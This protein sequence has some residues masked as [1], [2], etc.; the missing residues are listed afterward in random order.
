MKKAS[1]FTDNGSPPPPPL[2]VR[3]RKGYKNEEGKMKKLN[4]FPSIDEHKDRGRTS[5]LFEPWD[6]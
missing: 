2:N 3:V 1:F 6:I 4:P 5:T